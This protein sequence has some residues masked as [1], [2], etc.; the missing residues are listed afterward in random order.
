MTSANILSIGLARGQKFDFKIIK[1]PEFLV[2]DFSFLMV[3]L[4]LQ[5]LILKVELK[6]NF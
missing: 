3:V 5:I 2:Q 1:N 4:R 6:A